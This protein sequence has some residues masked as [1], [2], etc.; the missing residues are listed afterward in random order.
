MACLVQYGIPLTV[1]S[2]KQLYGWSMDE[3]VRQIGTKNNCTYCGVLRR[4]A[5]DRG[6]V[7]CN[8]DRIVTGHN[9]DDVAETVL[10]NFLRGDVPRRVPLAVAGCQ[11]LD[12]QAMFNCSMSGRLRLLQAVALHSQHHG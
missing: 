5:L 11:C 9:A 10:L 6:A 12:S 4:Q 2:Y 1:V 7:F 8:A 3:I